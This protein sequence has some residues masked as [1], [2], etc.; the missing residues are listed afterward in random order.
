MSAL[1]VYLPG[2]YLTDIPTTPLEGP[3]TRHNHPPP[4]D[5][6]TDT[7]ENISFPQLRLQAV[8]IPYNPHILAVIM[9][10]R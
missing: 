7:S 10:A 8:N 6:M 5:R 1:G 9:T 2:G 3:G 4:V